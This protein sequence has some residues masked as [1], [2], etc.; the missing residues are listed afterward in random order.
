MITVYSKADCP[1]CD[2]AKNLLQLKG[3]DFTEIRVDLD[4]QARQFVMNEGHRSVPQIYKDGQ[5]FVSGGYK[6]LTTLDE[7]IFQQLR[8]TQNVN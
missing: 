8:E 2:R 1:F 7:S 6:G 5:L 3:I 4:V